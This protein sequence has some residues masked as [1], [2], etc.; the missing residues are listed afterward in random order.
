LERLIHTKRLAAPGTL[1]LFLYATT[2]SGP[3][4]IQCLDVFAGILSIADSSRL[5]DSRL[6]VHFAK[7]DVKA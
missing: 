4:L 6:E 7:P 2:T 1:F 3:V 5:S